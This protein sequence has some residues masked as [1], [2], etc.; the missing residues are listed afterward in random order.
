MPAR[1]RLWPQTERLKATLL[2][3]RLS[4]DEHYWSVAADAA[5]SLFPYLDTRVPGLWRDL[6]LESGEFA[7]GPAPASSFYHLVGALA[8]LNRQR[9]LPAT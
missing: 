6:R 1:A 4:G 5:A 9:E 7:E 8:A 3:A 2:A